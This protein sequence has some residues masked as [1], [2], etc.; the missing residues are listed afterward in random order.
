MARAM[1]VSHRFRR[2]RSDRRA[3]GGGG[4]PPDRQL[5][6]RT[7]PPVS[8][9]RPTPAGGVC[10]RCQRCH[11]GSAREIRVS[12][13][14]RFRLWRRAFARLGP[15]GEPE[16]SD[17][18]SL[19]PTRASE[20]GAW[21]LLSLYSPHA[22]DAVDWSRGEY[23]A[24]QRGGWTDSP[25]GVAPK[26]QVRMIEEGSVL[27]APSL[28]GRAVDVAPDGFPHPVYRAGFALAVPA[29]PEPAARQ[30][31][32]PEPQPAASLEPEVTE[33]LEPSD[34]FRRSGS[35]TA[36]RREEPPEPKPER[37]E[38]RLAE[39]GASTGSSRSRDRIRTGAP[40]EPQSARNAG[41][42]TAPN[43]QP[44]SQRPSKTPRPRCFRSE[45]ASR[46]AGRPCNPGSE[47][48]TRAHPG[49]VETPARNRTSSTQ[50]RTVCST[51]P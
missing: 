16:F 1:P 21:W 50:R 2:A 15:R 46:A 25:S 37:H 27:L 11:V 33:E 17:A 23:S 43:A 41:S 49:P 34:W 39:P 29:P 12:S 47:S 42:R 26:K 20:E 7:G 22:S 30:P 38:P 6:I 40:P 28:R 4:R 8:N 35:R 44:P 48:R 14:G 5:P 19:L 45:P 13:A 9:S 10:F 51:E 31:Q 32:Q 18:S 3:L 24:T 36:V